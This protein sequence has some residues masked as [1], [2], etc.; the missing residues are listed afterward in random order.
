MPLDMNN[1]DDSAGLETDCFFLLIIF[2]RPIFPHL[3]FLKALLFQI[4]LKADLLDLSLKIPV[5]E[6]TRLSTLAFSHSY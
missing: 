5:R 6:L 1:R 3:H 2:A 4:R